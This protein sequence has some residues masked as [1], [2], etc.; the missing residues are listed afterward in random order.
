VK[1]VC[2][3]VFSFVSASFFFSVFTIGY[4]GADMVTCAD[5]KCGGQAFCQNGIDEWIG[6]TSENKCTGGGTMIC[7]KPGD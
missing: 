4:L 5:K 7:K 3:V 2:R 6:C 1:R